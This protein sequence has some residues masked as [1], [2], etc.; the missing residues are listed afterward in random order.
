MQRIVLYLF[1]C[2]VTTVSS[3]QP[4]ASTNTGNL[5]EDNQKYLLEQTTEKILADTLSD[6]R[7][8]G[9]FDCTILVENILK[10]ANKHMGARYRSGGKGPKTFD[11]SGF[12]S[13]VFKQQG[14]IFIGNN[15]RD[16]YSRNVPIKREDLQPGDLVFF[17]SS[18]SGNKVGH[19]GL[20]TEYDP[21]SKIFSFIHATRSAG[22]TISKSNEPIYSRTFLGARR[23][24][25]LS[26]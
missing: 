25:Q 6:V 15:S 2:S 11:C 24:K 3:A 4:K 8:E 5:L 23:V 7:F 12:T 18:R 17:T 26:L 20:V 14:N 22:I 19:V 1:I 16:Q 10:E 13:Y 21:Q 9:D